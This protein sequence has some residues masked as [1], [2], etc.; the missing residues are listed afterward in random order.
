MTDPMTF[1]RDRHLLRMNF[2][3]FGPTLSTDDAPEHLWPGAVRKG[4]TLRATLPM[5]GD[6]DGHTGESA[7]SWART[8]LTADGEDIFS[9]DRPL[10]TSDALVL[11]AGEHAYRLS[12]EV[13]RPVVVSPLSAGNRR[14]DLPF[15]ARAGRPGSATAAVRS[16]VLPAARGAQAPLPRAPASKCRTP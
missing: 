8:S 1:S 7:Y 2:G 10:N 15:R 11:P 12:T 14:V 4:D 6:G 13:A 16:P 9:S 3:V 5:F